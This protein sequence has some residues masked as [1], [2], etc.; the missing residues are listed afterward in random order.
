MRPGVIFGIDPV[1]DLRNDICFP[2]S[3]LGITNFVIGYYAV[4]NF[5]KF[6]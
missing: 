1:A 5:L 3:E 2:V 6:L 4:E